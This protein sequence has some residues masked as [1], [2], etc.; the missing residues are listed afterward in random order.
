MSCLERDCG[1]EQPRIRARQDTG[2][3]A[4][5]QAAQVRCDRHHCVFEIGDR[6]N[7]RHRLAC[8][9]VQPLVPRRSP[10]RRR[11]LAM[12][13]RSRQTGE[14][15]RRFEP[16]A[17]VGHSVSSHDVIPADKIS[18]FLQPTGIGHHQRRSVK[19]PRHVDHVEVAD[20][21][22]STNPPACDA[23][24]GN[25]LLRARVDG[26]HERLALSLCLVPPHDVRISCIRRR[27]VWAERNGPRRVRCAPCTNQWRLK[28]TSCMG[29]VGCSPMSKISAR[30]SRAKR[31][32]RPSLVK[33]CG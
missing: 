24:S 13:E 28:T 7:S 15:Q 3:A 19:K 20:R 14:V 31:S 1:S 5:V 18:L 27:T 12:S 10:F 23:V 9:T 25:R 32:S 6:A 26:K 16:R 30:S 4:F 21:L 11:R 22:N 33:P 17:I 8:L 2:A 29:G